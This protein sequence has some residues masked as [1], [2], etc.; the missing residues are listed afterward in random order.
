MYTSVNF[1]EYL[2]L[3][4]TRKKIKAQK[5]DFEVR[6]RKFVPKIL[7]KFI[8]VYIFMKNDHEFFQN[9]QVQYAPQKNL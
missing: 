2:E 1:L 3:M 9:F 5:Y 7:K 4:C 8:E 6:K